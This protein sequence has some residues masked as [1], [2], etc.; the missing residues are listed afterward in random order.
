M[1]SLLKNIR[2]RVSLLFMLALPVA[3]IAGA[4]NA[5]PGCA[6]TDAQTGKKCI[7]QSEQAVIL[8]QGI[9]K[10]SGMTFMDNASGSY[11]V[12]LDGPA[13]QLLKYKV[14]SL[15]GGL[16]YFESI[17]LKGIRLDNPRGLAYSKETA[18]DVYYFLDYQNSKG[19]TTS[20]LYR[21]DPASRDATFVD[22]TAKSFDIGSAEVYSLAKQN[23]NL[24]VSFDPSGYDSQVQ[25][26]RRGIVVVS[27]AN[28]ESTQ[29]A[30]RKSAVSR[31]SNWEE[32]LAGRPVI[33]KHLPGPGKATDNNRV[34]NSLALAGMSV[35]G[36]D[37]LWGTVGSDYIYLIDSKSGRGIFFFN[38]PKDPESATMVHSGMAFGAGHLWVIEPNS[39]KPVVHRVNVLE[40]PEMPYAGPKRFREI[41]MRLVSSVRESVQTPRGM[42]YHTF[43]HPFPTHVLGRQGV[44]PNTVQANDLNNLPD[45]KIEHLFYYPAGDTASQQ[46]YT[47][48][49]YSADAHPDIRKYQTDFTIKVWMREYKH[50]VYPHL[51]KKESGPAGT[52]YLDD[53]DVLYRINAN[54]EIY[55]AFIKRV[56]EYIVSEYGVD[57]DMDNPYWASRNISEYIKENYH[58]PKDNE[59]F[60]ATYDFEKGNYNSNPGNLKA[61][62]SADN[63]YKDNIT[64]CSG[65]G[66]MV[67]GALRSIGIPATWIG[68]SQENKWYQ[69]ETE[70]G[71]EFLEYNE[72]SSVGNGHR[73]NHVWLGEFY[74]WQRFD[75]TPVQPEG[76]S[77]DKKPKEVSQWD[78]MLRSAAGVE[79]H[80]VVHTIQSQFWPNLHVAFADC[81]EDVNGCGATRYNLLGTYTFP[82]D[83]ER[84]RNI[85]RFRAIQFINDVTVRLNEQLSG[86]VSWNTLGEWDIDPDATLDVVLEKKMMEKD[87]K[88]PAGYKE[89]KVLARGIPVAQTSVDINLK[90]FEPGLYRIKVTKVGDAATGNANTFEIK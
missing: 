36:T 83:F 48:A 86:T 45:T 52:S 38:M 24:F 69:W 72:E 51:A 63:N 54:P 55:P 14:N 78:F 89:I 88:Q 59:G 8:K 30:T 70:D 81:E 44:F 41:R 47:L 7:G 5:S 22:L 76:V 15:S 82:Q 26:I 85:I 57:P 60:Y 71:D 73:Y 27:V 58:Y 34:E 74:K 42:I 1:K 56:K 33:V 20:R 4:L 25:R 13:K 17:P 50:F 32:A 21:F 65:T 19:K 80:R 16:D 3:G 28:R 87:E 6:K 10:I 77:F 79:A 67:C 29:P 75:A 37:Y 90:G 9:S 62:L 68:V 46:D 12:I 66:A 84:S 11:L 35:D 49:T 43:L 31:P 40:N 18:G 39:G 23:D 53:D 64:A 2:M 61:E